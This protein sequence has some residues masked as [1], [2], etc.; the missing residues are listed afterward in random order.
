MI[1][2]SQLDRFLE[3]FTL[4]VRQAALAVREIVLDVMP[5]TIEQLDAPAKLIGYGTDR[6][7]RGTI[8][9]ITLHKVHINLMFARGV[10]LPDPHHLLTGTGK[11]A[12]HVKIIPD[13]PIEE[14]AIH[15]LL[16]AAHS[17]H[18]QK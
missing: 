8:C 10:D 5:G 12:R 1:E 18:V 6:T 13:R 16:Q 14:K 11:K 4:P 9:A 2:Q 3:P 15:A 7:Y 17:L